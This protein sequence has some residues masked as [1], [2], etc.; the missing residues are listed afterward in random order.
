MYLG[1][2]YSLDET[3]L[4]GYQ[5]KTMNVISR[6]ISIDYSC[7]TWTGNILGTH[8]NTYFEHK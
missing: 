3:T 8:R 6:S 1:I 2:D 5:K 4:N 7:A